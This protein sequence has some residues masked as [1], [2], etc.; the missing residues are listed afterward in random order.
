MLL[1]PLALIYWSYIISSMFWCF[2]KSKWAITGQNIILL[3]SF[4]NGQYQWNGN[5]S[6]VAEL[7]FWFSEKFLQRLKY[8]SIN[9]R[10]QLNA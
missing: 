3:P 6:S 1:Y 7:H 5:L 4:Y 2:I 10:D 9:F 8:I